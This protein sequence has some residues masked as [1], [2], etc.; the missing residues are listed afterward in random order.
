LL[1]GQDVHHLHDEKDILRDYNVQLNG[2]IPAY[3]YD[4]D[5]G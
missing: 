1:K 5:S 3:N 4:G 2:N